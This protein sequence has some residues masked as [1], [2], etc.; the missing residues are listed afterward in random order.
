MSL[1]FVRF[2]R[3]WYSLMGNCYSSA[4]W[5][6]RSV[7]GFLLDVFN[8]WR[9][10][11]L[12]F[13]WSLSIRFGQ[14]LFYFFYWEYLSLPNWAREIFVSILNSNLVYFTNVLHFYSLTSACL[15]SL[16][17][18]FFYHLKVFTSLLPNVWLVFAAVSAHCFV[19]V[20]AHFCLI[21]F[22]LPEVISLYYFS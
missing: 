13:L 8:Y 4:R 20:C 10:R 6:R 3:N 16:P 9:V 7:C 11:T 18:D 19:T 2:H 15:L 5:Q 21:I 12:G 22:S 1:F 14:L 17:H